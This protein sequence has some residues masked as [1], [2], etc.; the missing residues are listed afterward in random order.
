MIFEILELS[1][2]VIFLP[3]LMSKNPRNPRVAAK[4][5]Q[6]WKNFLIKKFF[7]FPERKGNFFFRKIS[8]EKRPKMT[9]LSKIT[10]FYGHFGQFGQ[11]MDQLAFSALIEFPFLVKKEPFKA[12]FCNRKLNQH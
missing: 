10:D 3:I 9:K 11:K 5:H 7:H 12:P 1:D 4:I 2:L 8:N 6:K